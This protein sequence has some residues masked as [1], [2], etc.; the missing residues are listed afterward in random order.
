[1]VAAGFQQIRGQAK[2][3]SPYQIG[4][5]PTAD[6]NHST[7]KIILLKIFIFFYFICWYC[8]ECKRSGAFCVLGN[9]SVQHGKNRIGRGGIAFSTGPTHHHPSGFIFGSA[10]RDEH[11]YQALDSLFNAHLM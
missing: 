6:E 5:S 7:S 8:H 1:M 2:L 10:Q 9:L 11:R 3:Q 4:S